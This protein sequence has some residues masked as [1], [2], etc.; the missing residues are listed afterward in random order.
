MGDIVKKKMHKI[1]G[2][3]SRTTC[4][5]DNAFRFVSLF[6]NASSFDKLHLY[7]YAYFIGYPR[8]ILFTS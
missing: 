8:L 6:F 2:N 3:I 1:S 7:V 5:M 4:A